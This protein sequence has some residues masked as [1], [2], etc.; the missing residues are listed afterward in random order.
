M[1][2]QN[3]KTKEVLLGDGITTAF[4]YTFALLDKSHIKVY[5]TDLDGNTTMLE[6][7]YSVDTKNC[8]VIYPYPFGKP[9]PAGWKMTIMRVVPVTQEMDL[10]N[11]GA[12]PNETLEKA[13]DKLTMIAQQLNEE[14]NR[15]LKADV[16]VIDTPYQLPAPAPGKAVGW[17][18]DGTGMANYDNPAASVIKA[19]AAAAQAA[20]SAQTATEKAEYVSGRIDEIA[21]ILIAFRII[22]GSL[23][24]EEVEG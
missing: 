5:L 22:D 9:L 19:E 14:S 17:N 6:S 12:L 15:S 13:Y 16:T 23:A 3:D 18:A 1:T 11:Q 24:I 10:I 21:P 7:G 20:E 4:P 8:N 2:V